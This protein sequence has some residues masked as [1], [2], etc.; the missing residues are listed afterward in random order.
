[1]M[2]LNS[3]STNNGTGLNANGAAAIMR[4]GLSAVS[5]NGTAVNIAN[6]ATA[7]TYSNNQIDD[8]TSPGEALGPI[9]PH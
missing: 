3:V 2:I 4:V 1:M 9:P 5:G 6:S 7:S 8:N